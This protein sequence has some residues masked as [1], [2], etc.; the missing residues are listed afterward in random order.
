MRAED[1]SKP[2]GEVQKGVLV[3]CGL[4]IVLAPGE[5][6]DA[7]IQ[8]ELWQMAEELGLLE[9]GAELIDQNKVFRITS[10][11]LRRWHQENQE[12]GEGSE[13]EE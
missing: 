3:G 6:E 2:D 11:N 1:E 8:D 9:W 13:A 7:S 12:D 10:D 5:E 4:A